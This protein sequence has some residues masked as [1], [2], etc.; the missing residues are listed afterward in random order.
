MPPCF[1]GVAAPHPADWLLAPV[2][3]STSDEQRLFEMVLRLQHLQDPTHIV[4]P[5]LQVRARFLLISMAGTLVCGEPAVA[6]FQGEMA[7]M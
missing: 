6:R 1:P 5:A 7:G 3:L 4:A 2:A